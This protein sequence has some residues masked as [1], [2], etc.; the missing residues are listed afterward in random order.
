MS[1][2]QFIETAPE[3]LADLISEK[4][5]KQLETF[6][7]DLQ[8]KEAENDLLSRDQACKLLQINSSTLWHWQ[9]KGKITAYGIGSRRYFKRSELLKS[10]IELKK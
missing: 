3:L 2:I 10:L 8:N 5:K 9:K 6:K 7:K 1:K 4:V